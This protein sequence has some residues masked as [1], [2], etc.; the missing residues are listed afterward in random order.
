MG[1][2]VRL[3]DIAEFRARF[4]PDPSISRPGIGCENAALNPFAFPV[5]NADLPVMLMI[6]P[7]S[8]GNYMRSGPF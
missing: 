6:Y 8:Y 4:T 1:A 3:P 7:E 5:R 2:A